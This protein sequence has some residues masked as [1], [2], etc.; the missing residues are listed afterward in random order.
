MISTRR[1]VAAAALAA[2]VAALAT[3]LANAAEAPHIGRFDPVATLDS[4]PTPDIATQ[5]RAG[6]PP[7]F[8]QAKQ[9]TELGGLPTPA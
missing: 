3:P 7:Q 8:V 5:Q 1:I 9:V 6:H 4:L 2:G